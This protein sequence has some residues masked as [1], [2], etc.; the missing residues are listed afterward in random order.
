[1]YD[2]L[3]FRVYELDEDVFLWDDEYTYYRMER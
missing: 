3:S 2:E 1:M